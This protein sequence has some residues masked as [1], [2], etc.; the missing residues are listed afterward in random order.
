M[1]MQI[2]RIIQFA[3]LF[4]CYLFVTVLLPALVFH[5]KTRRFPAAV[6]FLIHFTI[7]NFFVINLV[8]VLELVHISYRATLILSTIAAVVFGIIRMYHLPA[9]SYIKKVWEET[10]HCLYGELGIRSFF[11]RRTKEI[12][13]VIRPVFRMFRN[14]IKEIWID[15]PFIV[16]CAFLIWRV[17]GVR[18]TESFGF[19]ASDL[20]VH[21]YWINALMDN[22][23][24]V[25]GIYPMGM[26][27]VL[28][29]LA[30]VLGIPVYV[31]LT[32]F[33]LIQYTMM[34][35]VMLAFLK[36]VC[37]N[38]FLPYL[39]VLFFVG[40]KF[41]KGTAYSRFGATL[42]QEFGMMY[43]LPSIYFLT[44]FFKTRTAE[45]ESGVS[46]LRCES[47]WNMLGFA[48]SFSLTLATHFY[49]TIIAG[50]LCIGIA[51][52]Y[53]YWFIQRRY[54]WRVMGFGALS[55][56]FAFLP[57][58]AAFLTGKGLQ[59]SM[60]WAMNVIGLR[61]YTVLIF[62][63]ICTLVV[64]AAVTGVILLVAT[65]KGK[66]TFKVKVKKLPSKPFQIAL[67][68]FSFLLIFA[69]LYVGWRAST[70]VLKGYQD[71]V[72]SLPD[73]VW[74]FYTEAAAA[75]I[76]ILQRYLLDRLYGAAAL[77]ML[78]G[79]I[80]LG[81]LL[82]SAWL[83]LPSLMEPSRV[84]LYVGYLLPILPVMAMDGFLHL[85]G[86]KKRYLWQQ[87]LAFVLV[88]T[89]IAGGMYYNLV[90]S[91]FGAGGLEMN[92]A[93][94]CTANILRDNEGQNNTWT[95][96][97]A[98]DEYRMVEKY[99][100]HTETIEFLE[101]MEYWNASKEIKIPTEKVYFYIEKQPINYADAYNG[102]I[103]AVSEEGAENP[104]P[105]NNGLN[106][107]NRLNRWI[108]MSRMY[109][110]AQEFQK[111]Y[112]NEFQVYFENDNFVCFYIE[113]NVYSLYNFAIDYGYN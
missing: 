40:V 102:E 99:G 54:F 16:L 8:L 85:F 112:P 15:I 24:F 43:I 61:E 73:M 10:R 34:S 97:S 18:M 7:G 106:A 70:S 4:V 100:R 96:V 91:R 5:R 84:S 74:V 9:V 62:R 22:N 45:L 94:L 63:I 27:C 111:R 60:Y 53:W 17:G 46:G 37:K 101:D 98:N 64:G 109:Y 110:W 87:A 29:Y 67:Q 108:T 58:A 51:V 68:I 103:P 66:I 78:V 44:A 13:K 88:L 35:F 71:L 89:V 55:L 72:I 47:N 92:E 28:Y 77:S 14:W 76:I 52:G 41:Y 82:V 105:Q 69:I 36:G 50:V 26:H 6:R 75:G 49:D 19:G 11:S 93:M 1:S 25:A 57:M 33:W 86:L 113:Q 81:M 95:I 42:P 104:L 90:G 80:L 39:A 21:N 3:E 30:E 56:L 65:G 48:M 32:M 107:Y 2:L 38:R 59:G 23:L 83:G 20:P 79:N 12:K 31:T